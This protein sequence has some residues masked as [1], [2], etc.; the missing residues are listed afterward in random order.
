MCK[1]FQGAVWD[2]TAIIERPDGMSVEVTV[3]IPDEGKDK[4]FLETN[5]LTQMGAMRVFSL[6]TDNENRRKDWNNA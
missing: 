6:I 4:D 5:E 3:S 1:N 2:F